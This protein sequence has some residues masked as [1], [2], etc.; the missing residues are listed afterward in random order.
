MGR[1][2]HTNEQTTETGFSFVQKLCRWVDEL[3]A[4]DHRKQIEEYL[5]DSVDT[6]EV[7]RKIINLSRRGII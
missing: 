7:E 6:A 1:N 4:P 5:A 2:M 3:L